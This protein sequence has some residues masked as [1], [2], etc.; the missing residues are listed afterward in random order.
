M[1]L[2]KT[3]RLTTTSKIALVG[4]GGKTTAM[5][6][7]ARDFGSRVIL[8]TTTHLALD[9]LNEADKHFIVE[10]VED[11][12]SENLDL[13]EQILMFTGPQVEPNR[14][15]GPI[16][17]VLNR[18]SVLADHWGC[19]ILIE[20]DGA[21]QLPIKA[22]AKHEPSIPPFVNAVIVVIGLSGLGKPLNEKWVHRPEL[23]SEL[24][25]ISL[26]TEITS[27]HLAAAITSPRGGLKN[28]PADARK[29]L[30]VNQID[31]FPNWKTFHDY[32]P[33]LLNQFE[34]IG[35]SVLEDQMLLE[36]HEPIAG[37][38]L[39]AGG[40]TRFGTTKQLL[41]WKGKPLVRHAA[42]NALAGGLSP[43]VIVTGADQEN[44]TEAVK[45]LPVTCV[46]NPEWEQ[47]QSSSVRAGIESLPSQVGG[48]IFLLS[49]QPFISPALIQR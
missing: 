46:H 8:T 32:L 20:A 5:L 2:V 21:R 22:P 28:I 14:V 7:L 36:Y 26:G 44:V 29:L 6:Q 23:F 45:G 47:G 19:P 11:L 16:Q 12:P 35:F 1:D 24:V 40:S 38:I 10:S 42:E 39:A 9:Q 41:D 49:D 13:K 25:G 18:L 37:V 31:S 4:S 34:G 27:Q 33:L 43:V 17:D 48:T 15:K 3:F 30:L